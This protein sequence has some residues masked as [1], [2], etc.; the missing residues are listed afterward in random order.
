MC[1]PMDGPWAPL[2]LVKQDVAVDKLGQVQKVIHAGAGR[3][4][5]AQRLRGL[6]QLGVGKAVKDVGVDNLLRELLTVFTLRR[7]AGRAG[8]GHRG[9]GNGRNPLFA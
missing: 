4:D 3:L 9:A 1:S 5:P 2:V 6:K 7:C 8:R